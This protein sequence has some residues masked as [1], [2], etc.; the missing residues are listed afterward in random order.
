MVVGVVCVSRVLFHPGNESII[1]G[2]TDVLLLQIK[3]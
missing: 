3:V 2:S 1:K